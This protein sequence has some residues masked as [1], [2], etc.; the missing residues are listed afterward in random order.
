MNR[1]ALVAILSIIFITAFGCGKKEAPAPVAAP[2]QNSQEI[3]CALAPS[4]SS[5]V[6]HVSSVAGGGSAAALALAQATGFSVVAHS[7]GSLILTGAGGYVAGTLGTAIAGP[8]I[9]GVGL[10]VG[11]AAVSVELLCLPKNYPDSASKIN[12]AAT[13]FMQRS[14]ISFGEVKIGMNS[15]ATATSAKIKNVA[16]NVLEYAYRR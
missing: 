15:I 5:V 3:I 7:S 13:E 14:K 16:G 8:I 6:S 9:I 4:Q 11:G 2:M 12:A 10:V 1:S